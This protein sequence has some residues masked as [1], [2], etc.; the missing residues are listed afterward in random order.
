MEEAQITA[1]FRKM[2]A[3]LDSA[4]TRRREGLFMAEGTKCVLDTIEHFNCHYLIATSA[5]LDSHTEAANKAAT[6]M[7]A[8]RSDIERMSQLT[9]PQ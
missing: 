6:V 5:W 7:R 3:D 1:R 8:G 4:R 9:T 2:V